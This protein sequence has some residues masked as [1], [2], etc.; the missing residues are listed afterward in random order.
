MDFLSRMA[1]SKTGE[2]KRRRACSR[3]VLLGSI[4]LV[5][6]A[7]G[8]PAQPDVEFAT[9]TDEQAR[10]PYWEISD[11]AMSLRLVQR[12][13]DQSRAFFEARGFSEQQAERIAQSCVFQTVFKNLSHGAE[14]AALDYDLR[15]WVITVAGRKQGLKVREDW[16]R[17]WRADKVAAPARIAFEW[18]LLPT[19]QH[20]DPG[21]YNWG[22]S[23]F[24]LPPGTLFDL[25]VSWR[26]YGRH[27][28]AAIANIECAPDI[29]PTPA[30]PGTP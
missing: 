2:A 30:G 27:R 24:G 12:L 9:G 8:V 17:E 10:L 6:P 29:H 5:C 28:E 16:D 15:E 19:R 7:S 20:Y 4:L 3:V 13:P 22:M 25:S 26:Q 1:H 14:P 11:G 23:M 18:A 21:D